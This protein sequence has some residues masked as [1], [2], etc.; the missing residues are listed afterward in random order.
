[1]G[2]KISIRV[3]SSD[4]HSQMLNVTSRLAISIRNVPDTVNWADT[5]PHGSRK[6]LRVGDI[7]PNDDDAAILK[8]RALS[9]LMHFLVT[10]FRA[11]KKLRHLVSPMHPSGPVSKSTV[12]PMKILFRDEKYAAENVAILRELMKDAILVGNDEVYIKLSFVVA[13]I[14]CMV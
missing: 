12:V 5:T 6:N 10:E 11:L 14:H 13:Y 9:Y 8:G 7:L 2:Q 3:H 4:H 1:M